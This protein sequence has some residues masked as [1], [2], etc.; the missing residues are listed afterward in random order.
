[1]NT[2]ACRIAHVITESGPFGGAQRNTL[3]TLEGLATDGWTAELICGSGGRLIGE[4]RRLDI[5]VHV[6]PE[7]VRPVDL[8][9][10]CRAL[11]CLYRLYRSRQYHIVH[12]HSTKAGLLGRVAARWARVPVIVHTIHGYPFVLNGGPRTAAYITL[13]RLVGSVT[14]RVICVGEVLRQEVSAWKFAPQAKLSTIYSGID[15]A[16]YVPQRTPLAMKRELGR[17]SAWPIVGSVGHLVEAKAQHDLVE[18]V[19]LLAARYPRIALLL[20]GEGHL[21]TS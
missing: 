10:D 12:T 21:R 9:N 19:G 14:D 2:A 17:D 20:V 5:P 3:L 18:A 15:F 8:R 13:E 6:V 16:A 11:V 7:L 4:A 1:M